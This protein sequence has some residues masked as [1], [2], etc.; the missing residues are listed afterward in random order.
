MEKNQAQYQGPERRKSQAKYDGKERR[1]L[2]WP[3][4]PPS[5]AEREE[6]IAPATTPGRADVEPSS[7]GPDKKA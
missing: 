2:D 1:R 3:F 5:P 6:G 4:K 7:P